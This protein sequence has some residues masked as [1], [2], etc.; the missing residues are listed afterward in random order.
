MLGL[1]L[2]LSLRDEVGHMASAR[3]MARVVAR[4]MVGGRA[5]AR[6][7]NGRST[8]ARVRA[9]SKCVAKARAFG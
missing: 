8:K 3:V 1:G 4:G 7:G 6:A 2:G 9:L 5:R